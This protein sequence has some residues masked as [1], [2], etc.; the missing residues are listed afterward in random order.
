MPP[1]SPFVLI[2]MAAFG[3]WFIASIFVFLLFGPNLKKNTFG[4]N[5]MGILPSLQPQIAQQLALF[6]EQN[7]LQV[8]S[9]QKKTRDPLFMELLRPEIEKHIDHFLKTKLSEAFPL[10]FK[11]MGEKTQLKM[12]EAFMSEVENIFPEMINKFGAN[13]LKEIKESHFIENEINAIPTNTLKHALLKQA[14]GRFLQF[15][16]MGAGLGAVIGMIQWAVL[17]YAA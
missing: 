7:Y 17:S 12:K 3:G 15:K 4:L 16:L 8:N 10:L 14:S 11:F 5:K 6:L 13:L 2:F 1:I 9:I